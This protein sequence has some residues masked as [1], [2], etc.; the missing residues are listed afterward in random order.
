MDHDHIEGA[1]AIARS[2]DHLLKSGPLIVGRRGA[3][4]DELGGHL[5]TSHLAPR[6]QLATLVGNRE[7]MLGLPAR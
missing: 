1:L 7:I 2:L 3:S 6:R 4:L 5:P